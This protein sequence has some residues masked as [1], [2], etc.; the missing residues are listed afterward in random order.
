MFIGSETS[1]SRIS[2]SGPEPFEA[3]PDGGRCWHGCPLLDEAPEGKGLP[4]WRVLNALPFGEGDWPEDVKAQHQT[5]EE[6]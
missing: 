6:A 2:N 4:C 5:A 1:K 3:C